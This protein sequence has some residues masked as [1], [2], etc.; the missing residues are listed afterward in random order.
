MSIV[1][2]MLA[3]P[4]SVLKGQQAIAEYRGDTVRLSLS[5]IAERSGRIGEVI[6]VT[7]PDSRKTFLAEVTGEGRVL[8]ESGS[9]A[10]SPATGDKE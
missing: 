5:V 9:R 8:I 2:S 7:N 3:A 6:R 4:A 1:G 10:P